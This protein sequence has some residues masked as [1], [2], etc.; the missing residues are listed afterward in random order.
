LPISRFDKA[1]GVARKV[2]AFLSSGGANPSSATPGTERRFE[3]R[4]KRAE[5]RK[6]PRQRKSRHK[7]RLRSEIRSKEW[8][9][10]QIKEEL[11]AAKCRAEHNE[12]LKRKQRIKQV[13][14]RLERELRTAKEEATGAH[15]MGA[16]PD[17]VIIGAQKCGTTS[18]YDLLT[19]HPLVERAASKELH[20]F[21]NLFDEGV[22]WYRGN[23]PQPK[24]KDGH[25]TITGE[26]SPN[27]L[28]HPL[29]A[30]RMA[31]IIPQAR[32][33]VLLRNPVDRAFS[34]YQMMVRRG[35]EP[36]S[37]EEA[38]EAEG[39]RVRV[40]TNK[41][42][43]AD[44][45]GSLERQRFSYLSRGIYVD[46][47]LRWSESFSDEQML[48]L[49]TEDFSEHPRETLKSIPDF[50][51]LPDWEDW[52][53]ETW[54]LRKKGGKYEQKMDPTTRQRL[55]EYFDPHNRRLYDFLGVNFG[56]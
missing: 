37:F 27:Y 56:W 31:E 43:E 34:H 26:G 24:W 47:L 45:Y 51:G 40:R 44:Y 4:E 42:L 12:H 6:S 35:F 29:A 22:D 8:E 18:L 39:A 16:L 33:M 30:R 53:P 38:L 13:L 50:L 9:L 3:G 14:F 19:Q 54:E 48:V 41:L 32:L 49:K 10:L 7:K 17:F 55:E 52:E 15:V 2:K 21:D 28:F 36:L 5:K 23:F 46:Q 11:R 1:L 20:F 25:K